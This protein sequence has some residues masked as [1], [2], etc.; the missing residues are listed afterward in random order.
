MTM[1]FHIHG[2]PIQYFTCYVKQKLV[3]NLP[4]VG[5][6]YTQ[7]PRLMEETFCNCCH[8]NWCCTIIRNLFSLSF[9][10]NIYQCSK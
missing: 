5:P 9:V 1:P 3:I 10:F 7:P 2:F 8:S 4:W 6:F